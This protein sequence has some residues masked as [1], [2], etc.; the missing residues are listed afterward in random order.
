MSSAPVSKAPWNGEYAR[1]MTREICKNVARSHSPAVPAGR[2]LAFRLVEK[3]MDRDTWL[4]ATHPSN[5]T[6]A[7]TFEI[8]EEG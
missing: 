6:N 5:T 8:T 1:S 2:T 3:I 7:V 4:G